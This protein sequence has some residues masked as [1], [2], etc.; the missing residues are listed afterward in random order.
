[1]QRDADAVIVRAHI[2][3]VLVGERD[4]DGRS[5]RRALGE[6]RYPG[7]A[8]AHGLAHDVAER[9]SQHGVAMFLLAGKADHRRLAVTD[10]LIG[11]EQRYG[12]GAN[13]PSDRLAR[14]GQW[15][16]AIHV[17]AGKRVV[18]HGKHS[19]AAQRLLGFRS[20]FVKDFFDG[21]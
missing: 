4:I 10:R 16:Q 15:R 8:A 17:A 3:R 18:N 5:R 6:G 20:A 11:R 9:R 1:M 14:H 19:G 7:L 2:E 12:D 13:F 21:G